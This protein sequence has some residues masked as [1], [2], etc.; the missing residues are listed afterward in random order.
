L[1]SWV[2]EFQSILKA[3]QQDGA[4]VASHLVTLSSNREIQM[5]IR[6]ILYLQRLIPRNPHYAIQDLQ[7]PKHL[8]HLRIKNSNIG[9]CGEYFTLKSSLIS[10]F[11]TFP[12][13]VMF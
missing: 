7:P 11:F 13:N 8:L 4:P 9:V 1:D 3:W 10:V 5:E 2:G 12:R 6:A